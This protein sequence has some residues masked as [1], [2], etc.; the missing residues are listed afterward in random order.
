[1]A[2]EYR[3]PLTRVCLRGGNMTLPRTMIGLFPDDGTVTMVD[4]LTGAEHEAYMNGPRVVSGLGEL[5]RE[6][7]L[8]VNDELIVSRLGDAR[9]SIT[10]VVRAELEAAAAAEAEAD[11]PSDEADAGAA[12]TAAVGAHAAEP[13][14]AEPH[15]A[16]DDPAD[17]DPVE[18]D[19]VTVTAGGPTAGPADAAEADEAAAPVGAYDR[20]MQEAAEREANAA[21]EPLTKPPAERHDHPSLDPR[22][23]VREAESALSELESEGARS[24]GTRTE[25]EAPERVAPE[26]ARSEAPSSQ[27]ATTGDPQQGTL[28]DAGVRGERAAPADADEAGPDPADTSPP[29]PGQAG[30]LTPAAPAASALPTAPPAQAA[31]ARPARGPTYQDAEDDA[32]ALAAVALSSR[33]RRAFTRIG[34]RIEPLAT[35][36]LFLHAEM[37]RRRYKVLVQLLRSGERLDWA[38]LLSHRRNSPANYLAVVGDHVDLIRLSHPAELAR[39]T[40][41][42]WEALDRLEELHGSVPVT[43]LDLESHFARDGLFEQGLKRFEH[44]VAARVAERGAAS[45]VLTRL[46]RL[47][48]P[49]VF[50]LEELAQDVNLSRDVVLRILDRFAEAPMHLVAKVD[51]GEFLLR[52]S[53]D[54]ALA[55]LAAY[56]ESLR[57]RLP[58]GRREVITGLDDSDLGAD[59]LAAE[60]V[61]EPAEP[62]EPESADEHVAD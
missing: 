58:V 34:Y 47:K 54:T 42:S 16:E 12:A 11:E 53:V 61:A 60:S 8:D 29:V 31:G 6:H 9:F 26:S 57:Q 20:Y 2:H 48:A 59:L 52:Q 23:A 19:A 10:P 51:S 21:A 13:H 33:L 7:G 39:A 41:W 17:D 24:E 5:Y 1:M 45:E 40:L 50:L 46:A 44:G 30:T 28:W 25:G 22:L 18:D 3:Y 56:A 43:P 4:S 35:G 55:A 27:E 37:G 14:A 49:A 32:A 15:T 38:G 62:A 36:V